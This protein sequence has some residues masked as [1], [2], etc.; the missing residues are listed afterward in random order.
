[1]LFGA[2]CV[3]AWAF[4]LAKSA[5][6]PLTAKLVGWLGVAVSLALAAWANQRE[7]RRHPRRP[8]VNE[9][10][11]LTG[12]QGVVTRACHPRGQIRVDGELWQ[13]EAKEGMLLEGTVVRVVEALSLVL[14]VEVA[15]PNNQM[16]L[17]GG[18]GG[19][20]CTTERASSR[21]AARS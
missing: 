7:Y 17:T 10:S 18:E 1:M 11:G 6:H 14:T 12:A 2:A 15:P 21:V 3:G 19:A 20:R 8:V 16:Q 9:L 4:T 13:A 5:L